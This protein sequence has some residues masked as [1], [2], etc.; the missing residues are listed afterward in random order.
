METWKKNLSY[1]GNGKYFKEL[2]ALILNGIVIS[3]WYVSSAAIAQHAG[4]TDWLPRMRKSKTIR[5]EE[6]RKGT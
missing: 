2:F 1:A 3:G 4:L 6:N 5:N